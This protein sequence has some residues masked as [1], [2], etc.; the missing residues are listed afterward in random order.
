MKTLVKNLRTW[1]EIDSR[2]AK[3]NYE[4]FRKLVGPKV[5][6]WAVVKSN[7][8][9]H[10]LVTFAKLV[11]RLGASPVR[12]REGL[13]RAASLRGKQRASA[14]N[15]VDGFCVDS[16]VEGLRLR[17]EGIRKP[18]LVLG[19]TLPEL[20]SEAAKR[21]ITIT[22]SNFDALKALVDLTP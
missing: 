13:P 5:E 16:L 17:K 1:I 4:V 14:S 6:L 7:A 11:N 12:G 15:G 20:L 3:R 2:A 22:I 9:G 8:Y 10:G 21:N 18:I 19:P